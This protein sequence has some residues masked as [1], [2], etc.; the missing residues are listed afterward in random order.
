[1]AKEM[2]LE[3]KVKGYW[4]GRDRNSAA[5][6]V[7]LDTCITR[8]AEHGDWDHLARFYVGALKT[9]QGP[10]VKKILRAAFG[11]CLKFS[12]DSKHS[13]GGKFTKVNWPG[14]SFP[15]HESNT[16]S[17]VRAAISEGKG[18]DSKDF[19]K[20]LSDTLP[21]IPKK[22][23]VVSDEQKKK[24]VKHLSTYMDKLTADGFSSG[25]ILS[26]LQ[27]ELALKAVKPSDVEAQVINGMKVFTPNF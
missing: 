7:L 1:M 15:L 16:Y 5:G 26:M 23:R 3:A 14:N 13:T 17:V 12:L 11:N 24:V 10:N 21:A 2:S 6:L 9:G 4:T 8:C 27:K 19:Q 25:E 22:P 20:T 18:W